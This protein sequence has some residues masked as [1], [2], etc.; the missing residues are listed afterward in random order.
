MRTIRT[1]AR[2]VRALKRSVAHWRRLA[3][4]TRTKGEAP[5]SEECALCGIHRGFCGACPVKMESG[6]SGCRATP[7]GWAHRCWK[8]WRRT[9]L[10]AEKRE[11]LKAANT[12]L[13]YLENLLAHCVVKK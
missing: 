6:E 11:W 13:L 5:S 2:E 12:M 10:V 7:Y 8:D 1:T 9:R 3:T 4:D